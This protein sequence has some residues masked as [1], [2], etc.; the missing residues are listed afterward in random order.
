[1]K[2]QNDLIISIVAVVL[3]L[4]GVGV[5]YGTQRQV[6]KPAPP[7]SVIVSAPALP[8]GSVQFA[9]GLPSGGAGA[10]GAGPGGGGGRRGG[11]MGL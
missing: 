5:A 1:M 8:Q 6:T 11:I 3:M 7:E 2:N 4:I 10:P 9:N